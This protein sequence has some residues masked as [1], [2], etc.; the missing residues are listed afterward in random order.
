M[1][2]TIIKRSYSEPAAWD[3]TRTY[4]ITRDSESLYSIK[5]LYDVKITHRGLTISDDITCRMFDDFYSYVCD[6][7]REEAMMMVPHTRLT[8]EYIRPYEYR[9]M[10]KG[11]YP[12][13]IIP[14]RSHTYTNNSRT[15]QINTITMKP[16]VEHVDFRSHS[17]LRFVVRFQVTYS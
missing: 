15:H 5:N 13:T 7:A 10:F 4:T 1:T 2:T 6:V 3:C 11:D 17:E 16:I 8:I 14:V 12:I 9:A